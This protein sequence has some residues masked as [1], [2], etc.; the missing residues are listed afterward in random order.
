[1][2][3]AAPEYNQEPGTTSHVYDWMEYHPESGGTLLA[4]VKCFR[5]PDGS[6]GASGDFDPVMFVHNQEVLYDP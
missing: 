5:K 4:T 6:L 3:L 1:M 2:G